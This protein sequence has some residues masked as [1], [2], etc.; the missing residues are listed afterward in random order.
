M[1]D[2]RNM[3]ASIPKKTSLATQQNL[4]PHLSHRKEIYIVY[5]KKHDKKDNCIN[6]WWITQILSSNE[7]FQE[8]I[9]NMENAGKIEILKKINDTNLYK[10][11][12]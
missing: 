3:I 4:V 2:N 1:N 6:C 12:Y 5:P 9:I 7:G 8:A 10:I 11:N